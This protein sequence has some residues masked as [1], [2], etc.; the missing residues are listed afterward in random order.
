MQEIGAHTVPRLV[1]F[2][3]V[4]RL[5]DKVALL[6]AKRAYPEALFI[7]AKGLLDTTANTAGALAANKAETTVPVNT[8]TL[9]K[10]GEVITVNSE[11]QSADAV[12]GITDLHA[13]QSWAKPKGENVHPNAEILGRDKVARLMHQDH[14]AQHDDDGQDIGQDHIRHNVNHS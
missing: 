7:S 9:V 2:N 6:L 12:I 14:H 4:D 10:A 5:T 3:N 13:E 1:V 11:R 8:G